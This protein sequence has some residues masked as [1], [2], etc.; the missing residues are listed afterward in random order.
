[1]LYGEGMAFAMH[2]PLSDHPASAGAAF[3]RAITTTATR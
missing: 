3:A 2:M 1:M